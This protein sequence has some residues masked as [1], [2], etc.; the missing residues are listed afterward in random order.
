MEQPMYVPIVKAKKNDLDALRDVSN[1]NRAVVRPLLELAEYGSSDNDAILNRFIGRLSAFDWPLAPYVDL[2]SFLPNALVRNGHNATTEGFRLIASKGLRAIPTYGMER[3]DK[4]WEELGPLAL[5]LN[6]GFCFRID[7]DDLDDQ[8]EQTW[9]QILERSAEMNLRSQQVDVVIDLR[10][11][12]G[13]QPG[14]LDDLVLDFLS[15]RPTGFTPRF[16]A[17]AGSSALK[18]VVD[19]PRNGTLAVTRRE[20]LLWTRMRRQLGLPAENLGYGDY[21]VIHPDFSQTAPSPNANAKIRYTRG[22]SIHYFR[23]TSLYKP[24]NFPQ[25]HQLAR[26]V[27][28]SPHYRGQQYSIGDREMW[29]CAHRATRPGNLGTWVRIDQNHHIVSTTEQVGMLANRLVAGRT[30]LSVEELFQGV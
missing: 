20:L 2:Y 24:S 12:G 28:N 22:P 19:V 1:D 17:I 3:N 27:V 10:F 23:G 26:R 18:T 9:V 6:N 15:Y 5:E 30:N 8:S 11:I 16:T 29:E 21:G 7:I 4:L 13:I 25:Y 14:R